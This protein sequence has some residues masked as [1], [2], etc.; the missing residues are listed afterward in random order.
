M[1]GEMRRTGSGPEST[2]DMARYG[3]CSDESEMTVTGCG[4]G[5]VTAGPVEAAAPDVVA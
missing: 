2:G 1:H 5:I 3:S 4:V